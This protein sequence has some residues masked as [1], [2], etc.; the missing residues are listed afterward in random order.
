MEKVSIVGL[1]LAKNVF[2]AHGARADGSVA[3]RM[4]LSRAKLI[5]FFASV[6]NCLVAMEACA[7][8]HHWARQIRELGHEV[9]L[10][11]PIYVKPFVKRNKNDAADAEAIAEA[12]SR[13][14]MRFVAVKSVD[15]Q[16]SG[17]AFKTRDLLVRQRTQTINALRGHMA[18]Y[19]VVA[20][21]GP[22]HVARLAEALDMPNAMLPASVVS[23]CRLLLAH[24][25]SLSG[26]IGVLEKE[27]R[28]RA[29]R[30]EVA[31]RL[32]TIPGIGPICATAIEA[33]APPSES[34][35]KGR[36]FA[37]WLGLTPRQNSSGGK[38]RLGGTS[39]MG[40]RDLRRLLVGGAMT[41]VR[42]AS[43][44]GAPEDSWLARMLKKKPRLVVAVALANRT[45][46]IVWA[47]M[48]K[49]GVYQA[50]GTVTA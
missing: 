9:R 29:R 41:V 30:Y 34:F 6:P 25:A 50:S 20:P 49:G 39:K 1:D 7:S 18:E 5:G 23:L 28:E 13:P 27:L 21:N 2:Q 47:L 33:L 19:G 36:D 35:A 45:A 24:I 43:R 38:T 37:A 8:S 3:F 32:M 31:A 12:A 14:T 15:K 48:T 46:R 40:Q 42:W 10:I 11:P 26:Q 17:M 4:K 16:A 44:K 22:V